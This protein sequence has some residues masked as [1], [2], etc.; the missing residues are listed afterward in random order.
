MK[1]RYSL[2]IGSL[3]GIFAVQ[4][5]GV[6]SAVNHRYIL[7]DKYQDNSPTSLQPN[8]ERIIELFQKSAPSVAY[9]TTSVAVQDGLFSLNVFEIPQGAGSGVVWSKNG[10]IVTNFHV[11]KD[12][13][14]F[15]VTLSDQ[16]VW[17]AEVVGVEP[18]KDLAVLKIEAPAD[19]LSPMLRG[20]SDNLKIGQNVLAIGNPFGFDHSLT[21][22]IISGLGRE[23]QSLTGRPIRGMIQTDAAINPGNSGGPLLDSQGK[24]IGINTAIYSPTGTYSGVGFA[25]PIDTVNRIIPDLINFGHLKKPS[26]GIRV[27]DD[28]YISKQMR[29]KGAII[30]EVIAGG[31]AAKA[32]LKPIKID[33]YGQLLLGDVITG[34]NDEKIDNFN[35]LFLALEDLK[36]GSEAIL[37]LIRDRREKKVKILVQ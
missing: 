17:K 10:Y 13:S 6:Y 32:G 31:S 19:K 7:N 26:L 25:V 33:R 16:S 15:K 29:V 2:L 21:T 24:L 23:I 28:N 4:A 1:T 9:I 3:I 35:D 20:L 5:T 11:I 12:G 14:S 34:I 37:T 18:D 22:G 8:E 36:T 27:L 30:A